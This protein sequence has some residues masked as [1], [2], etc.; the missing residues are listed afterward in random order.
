[1]VLEQGPK[2]LGHH[3]RRVL[4][5]DRS[6]L[7]YHLGSGIRTL[8]PRKAGLL[9]QSGSDEDPPRRQVDQT[10]LPE[11]LKLSDLA[12]EGKFLGRHVF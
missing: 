5:A 6:P 2:L 4:D 12:L 1:M 3:I 11:L 8:G 10:Y 7:A 9:Y